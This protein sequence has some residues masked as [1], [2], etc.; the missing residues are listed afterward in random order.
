MTIARALAKLKAVE[1]E[2]TEF[3]DPALNKGPLF[4]SFK[5]NDRDIVSDTSLNEDAFNVQAKSRWDKITDL[6]EFHSILK[7]KI[8]KANNDT[9]VQVAGREMTVAR[10][11]N[12]KANTLQFYQNLQDRLRRE[13]TEFKQRQTAVDRSIEENAFKII[14]EI[15]DKNTAKKDAIENI[16]TLTG[17]F[18]SN[19][20]IAIVDPI[21][22]E[23]QIEYLRELVAKFKE[24][25]DFILNESNNK[26]EIEV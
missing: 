23:K 7:S 14:N 16:K 21:G 17:I 6:I 19:V 25:I 1:A 20:G 9:V 4:V 11:L 8:A 26:I 12:F 5:R 3:L 10:A 22:V 18:T 13:L 2:I 15:S 24:E